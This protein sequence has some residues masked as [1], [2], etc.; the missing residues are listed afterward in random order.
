MLNT[1]SG[2]AHFDTDS[3]EPG[4]Y[5]A[6]ATDDNGNTVSCKFVKR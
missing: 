5:V 6:R 3:L 4:F 1:A 2:S